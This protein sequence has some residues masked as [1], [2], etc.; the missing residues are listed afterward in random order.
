MRP[1]YKAAEMKPRALLALA[2]AASACA[3]A[4]STGDAQARDCFRAMDV[5]GYGIVDQSHVRVTVSP[6]R[7]YILTLHQD[8]RNLDWATTIAI[9]S[10]TSFVCTGNGLGVELIGGDPSLHYPIANIERA[11]TQAP[12]EQGR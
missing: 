2:I 12:P 7:D 11:P 3:S 4:P 10:A 9:R 6:R 1:P 5:D 8:T